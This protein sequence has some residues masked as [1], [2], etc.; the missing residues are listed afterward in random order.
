MKRRLYIFVKSALSIEAHTLDPATCAYGAWSHQERC[1]PRLPALRRFLERFDHQGLV[2]GALSLRL[3][4]E[5]LGERVRHADA[6]LLRPGAW[7]S[8]YG[9]AG[10][11]Y[12]RRRCVE[13]E[14]QVDVE[15]KANVSG[16]FHLSVSEFH[17]LKWLVSN[18]LGCCLDPSYLSW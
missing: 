7:G 5:E 13:I 15:F 9:G 11:G 17:G 14:V 2:L 16:Q 1:G 6:H 10:S 3:I 12:R 18:F 8:D 4:F